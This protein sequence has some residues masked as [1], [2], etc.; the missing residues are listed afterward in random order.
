VINFAKDM[1]AVY[2][3]VFSLREKLS[4]GAWVQDLEVDMSSMIIELAF[5]LKMLNEPIINN[6]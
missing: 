2:W 5:K 4:F 1:D 6:K 3:Q